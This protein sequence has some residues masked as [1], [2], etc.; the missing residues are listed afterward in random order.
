MPSDTLPAINLRTR[1]GHRM[2]TFA[3]ATPQKAFDYYLDHA[4][5]APRDLWVAVEAGLVRARIRGVEFP[6]PYIGAILELLTWN[7][8]DPDEARELPYY[9]EVNVDDVER[10][11]CGQPN[12]KIRKGRPKKM[13]AAVQRDYDLAVRI[14]KM[15]E[16][17]EADSVAAAS[18]KW[19]GADAVAGASDDAK[20]K[21]LLRAYRTWFRTD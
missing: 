16:S 8:I 3:W 11:L 6:Q 7:A 1:I 10:E 18:R 17:G 12:P 9:I 15:I 19:I 20:M 2:S 5:K 21:R 13:G 4:G 14:C